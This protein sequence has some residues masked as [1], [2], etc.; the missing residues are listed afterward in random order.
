VQFGDDENTINDLEHVARK[1]WLRLM[2]TIA[3][4]ASIGVPLLNPLLDP[5]HHHTHHS[6]AANIGAAVA[7]VLPAAVV[8]VISLFVL[9]R[10]ARR[11]KGIFSAP[12]IMG[13]RRSERRKVA[14]ALRR[15]TPSADPKLADVEISTARR[16]IDQST[17]TR[18][19]LALFAVAEA[20]ETLNSTTGTDK[21]FFSCSAAFFVFMLGLQ[22]LSERRA[23]RY[24]AKAL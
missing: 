17:R 5:S 23:R 6:A 24:L 8:V 3:V 21:V 22:L 11:D 15:A 19:L 7:I 16:V 2:A 14:R 10:L 12:T 13:L 18:V 4:V 9:R 20:G 1:R